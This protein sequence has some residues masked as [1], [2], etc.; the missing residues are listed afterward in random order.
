MTFDT[1]LVVDLDATHRRLMIARALLD[2]IADRLERLSDDG[3]L[4]SDHQRMVDEALELALIARE[5][6]D[7]V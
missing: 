6:L 5:E 7:A 2:R 3:T 4:A 1:T